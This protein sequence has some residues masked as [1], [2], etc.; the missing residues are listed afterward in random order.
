M[1][2]RSLIKASGALALAS[3]ATGVLAH[4]PFQQWVVYRRKHLLIGCHKEDGQTYQLAQAIVAILDEH[5]PEA[6]ARIARAPTTGRLASLLGTDQLDVALLSHEDAIA[7]ASGVEE[8]TPYGSIKLATLYL[9]ADYALVGRA[10][11][12]GR[13]GWLIASALHDSTLSRTGA[14]SISA[15]L[16]WHPGAALYMKGEPLPE[17]V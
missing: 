2:R 1:D 14:T 11:I 8:F 6:K 16:P 12:P 13:H 7:M 5:L 10:E 9:L 4:T 17:S 3:V 15:P